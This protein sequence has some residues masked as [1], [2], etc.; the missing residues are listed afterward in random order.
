[1]SRTFL[2]AVE[3]FFYTEEKQGVRRRNGIMLDTTP[4]KII[5]GTTKK[6]AL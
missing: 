6:E 4:K 5:L 3:L 1:M 2:W